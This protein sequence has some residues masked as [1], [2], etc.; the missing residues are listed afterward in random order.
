MKTRHGGWFSIVCLLFAASLWGQVGVEDGPDRLV[1][2]SESMTVVLGKA[3]KGAVL[4]L[5]DQATGR[6]YAAPQADPVLFRLVFTR[7]GEESGATEELTSRD[8]ERVDYT[9]ERTAAGETAH[10]RYAS[11]GGRRIEVHCSVSVKPGDPLVRW[12]IAVGGAEPLVLEE[13]Q[14]PLVALADRLGE[15]RADDYA[16]AG[17]TEDG[18]YQ[19]PGDWRPGYRRVYTQ[20]G[21]LAAQFACYYDPQ[22]GFYTATQDGVGYP[23]QLVIARGA[24][25]MEYTWSHLAYH[26]LTNPYELAYDVVLAAFRGRDAATPA[27]W[28]DAA[29]IHKR[30]A[31][32]QPWCART[33]AE[34]R[35]LPDWVKKGTVRVQWDLRSDGLPEAALAWVERR[36]AENF[37]SLPPFVTFFGFEHAGSW[38][39]PKYTPF[40]PSDEAFLAASRGIAALGGHVCLFP[41]TYQWSLTFNRQPDGGFAWDDRAEFAAVGQPHAM[42]DRDGSVLTKSHSWLQGGETAA[43][44]RGD[45]W[46]R[47]FFSDSVAQMAARGVGVVQLD[48]VVGGRWPAD[49]KGVCF[50]RDHG[51]P[52]GHGRWDVDAFHDQMSALRERADREWPGM[53]FSMESPQELFAQEFGLFDYRHSRSVVNVQPWDVY[54]KKHA[55]VFPYLYHEFVP[56]FHIPSH[57]EPF[58][59]ILAHAI[60]HGEI[61]SFKPGQIEFPGEPVVQNGSFETWSDVPAGWRLWRSQAQGP[62]TVMRDTEAARAGEAALRI[63]GE[64]AGETVHVYQV[65]PMPGS[66][67]RIGGTYR[68]RYWL[69]SAG[70]EGEGGLTVEALTDPNWQVWKRL[71]TWAVEAAKEGDWA[72]GEIEFRLPEGTGAVRLVSHLTGKGTV[73]FDGVRLEAVRGD[74]AAAELVREGNGVYR[75]ASQWSRLAAAGAG[76][77]LMQ[78]TTLHPPPLRT[79]TIRQ[80]VSTSRAASLNFQFYTLEKNQAT[81]VRHASCPLT[82]PSGEGVWEEKVLELAV[83]PGAAEFHIPLSL[84]QKG[85][86]L[87]DDFELTEVGGNGEN[88]LRNGGF[89]DWPDPA[90]LPPGWAHIDQY[91][92]RVFTG[93]YHRE[94]QDVQAGTYAIR[95]ANPADEDAIHVKQVLPVDGALL[96]VGKTYQLRFWVKVRK[97]ARWQ[98]VHV[99]H[100][101]PAILHNAFR[102]P[103]GSAAAILVNI[104]DEARTGTLTWGGTETELTLAPWEIR[105]VEERR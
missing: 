42:R 63:A 3:Q 88:L 22:G 34:R 27:N 7:A 31:L 58:P 18:R 52:A 74:G 2:R 46:T 100:E 102:A 50:S 94:E 24:E 30:W 5:L 86:L 16:L 41:S 78:G 40:Y 37:A 57:S 33:V 99:T 49:G 4:S 55:A 87:F 14:F 6:E 20:P 25:G 92:G 68:L 96:S 93:T 89:E 81:T 91:Q 54:P 79:D 69:K 19:A 35:D 15:D 9:V 101:F 53:V 17:A 70:M 105:L 66:G 64:Q 43:L 98:P 61:P 8:A 11:L 36:W 65:I 48:Q 44:C 71:D 77:Y 56:V 80:T 104:T 45:A 60:V 29:D 59:L 21:A 23:K 75:L 103:D 67:L 51:H 10:L 97:V 39:A 38:I 90:A 73:W 1:L 72:E 28:R 26:E 85:E 12:R 32:T 95:L 13:S 62:A 82:I 83:T 47:Q 84:R 76:K